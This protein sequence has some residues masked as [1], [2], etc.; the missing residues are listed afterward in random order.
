MLEPLPTHMRD[1]D[2]APG[3]RM[4]RPGSCG[5]LGSKPVDRRPVF[6]S[7]CLCVTLTFA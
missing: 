6:A 1:L 2:A 4:A 5:H 7:A 3:C